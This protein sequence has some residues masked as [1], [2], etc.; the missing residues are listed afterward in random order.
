MKEQ[1]QD[2]KV[3]DS[4]ADICLLRLNLYKLIQNKINV[5]SSNIEAILHESVCF[6][7]IIGMWPHP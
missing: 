3:P 5:L 4:S 7:M 6:G 2:A 1:K